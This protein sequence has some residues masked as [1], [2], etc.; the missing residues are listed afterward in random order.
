MGWIINLDVGKHCHGQN[1]SKVIAQITVE[2]L[3]RAYS[4]LQPN[5]SDVPPNCDFF[6]QD[7]GWV[8]R[9]PHHQLQQYLKQRQQFFLQ[10]LKL[11]KSSLQNIIADYS[12]LLPPAV[13]YFFSQASGLFS[14]ENA[15]FLPILRY[16]GA[17][18]LTFWCPFYRPE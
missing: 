6:W 2:R 10:Q 17:N 12:T 16:F 8:Q 3:K 11:K 13:V 18:L 1:G 15:E 5:N 9:I 14:I 7:V 4:K